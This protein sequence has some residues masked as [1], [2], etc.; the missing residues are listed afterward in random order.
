MGRALSAAL[1]SVAFHVL[2]G[3]GFALAPEAT[4][5]ALAAA[6]AF[7]FAAVLAVHA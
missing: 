2:L 7:L 3:L 5:Y 6:V 1:G 4:A